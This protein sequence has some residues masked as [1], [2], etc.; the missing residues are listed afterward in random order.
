MTC[1]RLGHGASTPL[2]ALPFDA[3]ERQVLHIARTFFRSFA[4]PET[5][6]WIGGVGAALRGF[7]HAAAPHIYVATLGA[8]QAMRQ[9]RRSVFR[10][11]DPC[12]PDCADRATDGERLFLGGLRAMRDGA[13]ERAA[14]LATIL[15]EGNDG[16]PWL[17][18]L[19]TLACQ[20]PPR[21]TAA[22]SPARHRQ[23]AAH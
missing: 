7:D 22:G 17:I 10:F 6:A 19:R 15:C 2:D 3:D 5:Q 20:M 1:D 11:N 14:A 16:G 4:M 13:P 12:C 21:R 9:S 8:V 18:A 23:D